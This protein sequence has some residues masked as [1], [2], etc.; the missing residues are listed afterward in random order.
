MWITIFHVDGVNPQATLVT[1]FAVNI[2][3]KIFQ[4]H[5]KDPDSEMGYSISL[6]SSFISCPRVP[7]S[8]AAV[9]SSREQ[10]TVVMWQMLGWNARQCSPV[11]T[12]WHYCLSPRW[13]RRNL[14]RRFLCKY[15][16]KWNANIYCLAEE[17]I[18]QSF[19]LIFYC[20]QTNVES[21]VAVF[22]DS[23]S[24]SII[25]KLWY[26]NFQ[27]KMLWH[28]ISV[29]MFRV[30]SRI[31]VESRSKNASTNIVPIKVIINVALMDGDIRKKQRCQRCHIF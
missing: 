2:T 11:F 5:F 30:Q 26:Y 21:W 28:R 23:G 16:L 7:R 3:E 1:V 20:G 24:V 14:F 9:V 19:Y 29:Q 31:R 27:F 22:I 8:I 6:D 17:W 15:N 4:S 12:R 25:F 13:Q 18:C 10:E